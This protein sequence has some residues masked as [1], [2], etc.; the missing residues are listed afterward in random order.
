MSRQKIMIIGAIIAVL[1][2]AVGGGLA[3]VMS[4]QGRVVGSAPASRSAASTSSPAVGLPTDSS[5]APTAPQDKQLT[6]AAPAPVT[7]VAEATPPTPTSTPSPTATALAT[8][9]PPATATLSTAEAKVLIP[10]RISAS[11][12]APNSQDARGAITTFG[13]DNSIDGQP[14]TAWRVQGDGVNQW[15][16]LEFAGP[17]ALRELQ[18]LPGYAKIDAIDGT[19]RFYQNRR[20]RRIRLEFSDGSNLE[21]TLD[22][23]PVLQPVALTDVRT[24]SV[25]I[26]IL[27][28]LPPA[29]ADGREYTPISEIVVLG[30]P[31]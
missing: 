2:T 3:L 18:L 4:Q 1:V 11:S 28:S 20:V 6:T 27:E 17:V 13:P 15:L 26:V 22:D 29:L 31:L 25:R 7:A 23:A 14:E 19:N 5:V 30:V 9:T 8:V 21:V 12:S 24:T 10:A 16:L